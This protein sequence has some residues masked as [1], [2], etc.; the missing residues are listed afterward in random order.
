MIEVGKMRPR[1]RL[2]RMGAAFMK[3]LAAYVL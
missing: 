2:K 3:D 1:E